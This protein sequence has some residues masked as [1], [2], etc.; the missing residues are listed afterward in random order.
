ML[1][2]FQILI[3]NVI[4]HELY[5]KLLHIQFLNF[6]GQIHVFL[7]VR[8]FVELQYSLVFQSAQAHVYFLAVSFP[9]GNFFVDVVVNLDVLFL[10]KGVVYF[11]YF[12]VFFLDL[13]EGQRWINEICPFV[14]FCVRVNG[15]YVFTFDK[16]V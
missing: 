1:D 12:D 5:P 9:G 15:L 7:H 16:V 14:C 4:L 3:C 8:I 2:N 10:D 6:E 13:A 11:T